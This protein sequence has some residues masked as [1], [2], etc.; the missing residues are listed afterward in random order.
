MRVASGKETI[1]EEPDVR[2]IFA[3]VGVKP[4]KIRRAARGKVMLIH[5]EP[6]PLR[7]EFRRELATSTSRQDVCCSVSHETGQ[8]TTFSLSP[9]TRTALIIGA[10]F[11]GLIGLATFWVAREALRIKRQNEQMRAETSPLSTEMVWITGGKFTMGGVGDDVPPDE[12]PRHDVRVDG[13]WMD[14]TEVTNEQF[15]AFVGAT[16][17][18]TVAERP[19]SSKTTPGLLPEFEGKAAS[20]CFLAPKPGEPLVGDAHQWWMPVA[21]ANWRHPEGEGS[22]LAGRE[23]HPVVHVCYEDAV[24]YC[25][26][27]GKRLP[28]EAEWEYAARGGI[29]SEPFVWGAEMKPGGKW[30]ANIWQGEFPAERLA[31]D[32][33]AGTA[34]AG[35]FPANNFGLHDMAGNVWEL[36]EDWYRSDTYAHRTKNPD[37]AA[38]RNPKGPE[39]SKDPDE[40]GVWKK[41]TRGGSF[42]CADNYCRGYRPSARMK[43]APDTGLQNTGFRCVRDAGTR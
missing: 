38:R 16:R 29:D 22:N 7:A 27:A 41:V 6:Q 28:T 34:P 4:T 35:S 13:F 42:M 14:K 15:A 43:T 1:V 23:K 33:F 39:D 26:W 32:G 11:L 36:T 8:E 5:L 10:F 31:E 3:V 24:A 9:A 12:L 20:L 21:G 17:Y 2:R 30:M 40:P 19:L 37:R 25:K 18:V